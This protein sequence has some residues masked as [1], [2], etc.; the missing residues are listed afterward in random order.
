MTKTYLD[1]LEA[2]FRKP[3]LMYHGTSD[4]VLRS[5]L[6]QGV[7][8][9]PKK[10]AWDT[11]H[12]TGHHQM[13]RVSVGGSYWTTSMMTAKSSG[14]HARNV[15]GGKNRV[16]VIADIQQQSAF[17]D[18]DNVNY[19]LRYGFEQ[20]ARKVYGVT[21][22]WMLCGL[23][24][25][26]QDVA[27]REQ[28]ITIFVESFMEYIRRER[29]QAYELPRAQAEELLRLEI[30]RELAHQ[31]RGSYTLNM[32]S[33]LGMPEDF[34]I[35]KPDEVE[36][37]FLTAREALTRTYKIGVYPSEK[38]YGDDRLRTEEIVGY[39]G[40]NKI[41]A[42]LE[43]VE[44]MDFNR[45]DEEHII[46]HYG[47]IPEDFRQQW[48]KGI[49]PMR[50][51]VDP[52]GRVIEKGDREQVVQEPETVLAEGLIAV[53]Q[54]MLD[55]C[56]AYV[57][58]MVLWWAQ[59]RIKDRVKEFPQHAREF[60]RLRSQA[61]NP[62]P[63]DE[64]FRVT[65]VDL[66]SIPL[67]LSDMPD[68]YRHLTPDRKHV[69]CAVDFRPNVRQNSRGVWLDQKNAMVVCPMNIDYL[70]SWPS[71]HSAPENVEY[72]LAEIKEVLVHELRHMVQST[73]IWNVDPKQL[74]MHDDYAATIDGKARGAGYY[75]SP[76]EF[77]TTIGSAAHS[78]LVHYRIVAEHGRKPNMSDSIKKFVGAKKGDMFNGFTTDPFFRHWKAQD[79]SK[80][81]L[82]V[83]KFV[84]EVN[85]LLAAE[86]KR[87]VMVESAK[88]V[89]VW[90]GA[91]IT[92]LHNPSREAFLNFTKK[93]RAVRGLLTYSG[94]DIWLW[95]GAMAVHP[96]LIQELGLEYIDCIAFNDG[97]W[98]GPVHGGDGYKPAVQRLTPYVPPKREFSD[99]ELLRILGD[100]E[101]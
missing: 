50:R 34:Y 19:P 31:G 67:D 85:R 47:S 76:I 37:D 84:A 71:A 69:V 46:L 56:Y 82:A 92:V 48:R 83:N 38:S 51:V 99:E 81:R 90:S 7:I 23:F 6:K 41:V 12:D 14:H 54:T 40:A 79:R 57:E 5:I 44:F 1:L 97:R 35:P 74:D 59:D 3:V 32:L 36:P 77:D 58:R 53:P 11:D 21:E 26:D 24:Y 9:F 62:P 42:V 73:L 39:R 45:R 18:E 61:I 95:D 87:E 4:A 78:F 16:I 17:S 94:E 60:D 20:A 33:R 25:T 64:P 100:D 89:T 91:T 98:T 30:L 22:L 2:K 68:N 96:N 86:R 88:R 27:K 28:A 10:R 66:I 70:R 63:L 65:A 43:I 49:G 15:L 93:H 80:W 101:I 52:Q 55:K 75:T 8:P 72:A 13:S 29:P